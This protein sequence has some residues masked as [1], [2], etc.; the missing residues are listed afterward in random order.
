VHAL[1]QTAE[2]RRLFQNQSLSLLA[3]GQNDDRFTEL[4]DA[5]L[6]RQEYGVDVR[7]IIRG[8]F[9]PVRP[10]ERLQQKGFDMRKVRL[11]SRCHTKGIIVDGLRVLIGSHNWTNQGTLANRDASLIF[12]D[13]EIAR[14]FEEIFW[15]DWKHLARQSVGARR[16]RRAADGEEAPAGVQRVSW[17]EIVYG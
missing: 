7:I 17:Q 14:Y 2:R 4:V 16:I 10:L 13:E 1:I 8:E 12:E 6:A 15:F 3:E 11:Q 5:L 9:V